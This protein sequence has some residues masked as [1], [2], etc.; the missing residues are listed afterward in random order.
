MIIEIIRISTNIP[1]VITENVYHPNTNN[2]INQIIRLFLP[3]FSLND[4]VLSVIF[5]LKSFVNII[6]DTPTLNVTN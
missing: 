6:A 2:L 4:F 1:F 3:L 5:S